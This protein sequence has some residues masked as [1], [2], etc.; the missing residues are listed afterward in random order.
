MKKFGMF[1][2]I[3]LPFYLIAGIYSGYIGKNLTGN[4][5]IT[6]ILF[7]PYYAAEIFGGAG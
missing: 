5:S 7:W 4:W 3:L 6:A 2:L 1:L